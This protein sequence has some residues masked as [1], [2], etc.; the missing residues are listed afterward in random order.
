MSGLTEFHGPVDYRLGKVL[1]AEFLAL[2]MMPDL[3]STSRVLRWQT[4]NQSPEH[5]WA[6][7]RTATMSAMYLY[8]MSF[9]LTLCEL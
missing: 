4:N 1:S 9:E 2:T 6:F 8:I 7:F 3:D 5:A